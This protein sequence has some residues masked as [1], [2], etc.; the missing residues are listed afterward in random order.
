MLQLK[1]N[2]G[3]LGDRI[4]IS[5]K[6]TNGKLMREKRGIEGRKKASGAQNNHITQ[7]I[8]KE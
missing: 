4:E 1:A 8:T 3:E 5:D 2:L 7:S 6:R